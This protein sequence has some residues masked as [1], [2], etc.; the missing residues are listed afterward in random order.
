[1]SKLNLLISSAG[2]RTKLV[3]YFKR[4]FK[5]SGKI[6]AVDCD[7]LAPALYFADKNF[8]VPRIADPG[9]LEELKK[10]CLK[11]KVQAIISLIDPELLLMAKW[12]DELGKLGIKVIVSAEE[13]VDTCFD[14]LKMHKFL[15]NNNFPYVKTYE[16]LEDFNAGYANKDI[17]FPVVIKPIMG[18]ASLG[19]RVVNNYEELSLAFVGQNGLL[20]QEFFCGE[21]FGVDVYVDIISKEVIS[22]FAKKKL[23]MRSGETDK[24]ISVKDETLFQLIKDFITKLGVMGP[25]DIDVFYANDKYYISEVN[26][27]FG[28][29]H[30]LA[31]EC[32]DNY[33]QYIKNNLAGLVNSVNIGNYK[34]NMLMLKHDDLIV[35]KWN[36]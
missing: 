35:K 9:Y 13:A 16:N 19:L 27:R 11:E 32:G 31:Y 1:M 12:K 17:K 28:G 23:R 34:E 22:I 2:R 5:G 25:I 3:E 30:L 7:P 6:I 4:E 14:K 18:S 29:G 26:P 8:I 10:L 33:P 21:E 15:A 36:A 24:A 20:I